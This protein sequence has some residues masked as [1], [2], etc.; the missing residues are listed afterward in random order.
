MKK[1]KNLFTGM[2]RYIYYKLVVPM[3]RERKNPQ[4]IA[5]ATAV[6]I[7][8]G[9]TPMFWQMN[10]V[11]VIWLAARFFKIHFS[12]PIGFAWTWISNTFTNIPLF[13]LY[14]LTGSFLMGK[15]IG[16]YSLFMSHFDSGIIDGFKEIIVGYGPAILLG[17]TV[18]MA[19]GAVIGY[20]LSYR[21]AVKALRKLEERRLNKIMNDKSVYNNST[22]AY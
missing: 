21:F 10:L 9:F 12:L 22:T 2:Y 13:Y 7:F 18:Y 20:F 1:I 5:R 15:E 3:K 8:C 6:G 14:Y 19:A 16:G 11:F 17:S 4:Y